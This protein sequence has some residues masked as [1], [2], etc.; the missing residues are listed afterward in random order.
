MPT[1]ARDV[2]GDTQVQCS[3]VVTGATFEIEGGQQLIEG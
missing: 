1:L 3:A 2:E